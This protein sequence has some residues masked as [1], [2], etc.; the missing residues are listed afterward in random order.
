M[1]CFR[2]TMAIVVQVHPFTTSLLIIMVNGDALSLHQVALTSIS[3]CT[4]G[5]DIAT[6]MWASGPRFEHHTVRLHNNKAFI[7]ISLQ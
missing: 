2:F 6:E 7:L 4:L 1:F 3:L 5:N